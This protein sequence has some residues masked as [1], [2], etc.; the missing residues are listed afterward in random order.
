MVIVAIF[1][2][3]DIVFHSSECCLGKDFYTTTTLFLHPGVIINGYQ[4]TV[5]DT[6]QNAGGGTLFYPCQEAGVLFPF[7][8]NHST[9][10]SLTPGRV[11][12]FGRTPVS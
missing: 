1:I 2:L 8:S 5:K 9:E 10:N 6:Q 3:F 7:A 11:R 4:P 12:F